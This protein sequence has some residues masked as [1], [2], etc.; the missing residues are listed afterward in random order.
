MVSQCTSVQRKREGET[1]D[2]IWQV[3]WVVVGGL[4]PNKLSTNV[5]QVH[6]CRPD[7][8]ADR[9]RGGLSGRVRCRSE[10]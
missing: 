8:P 7:L 4:S 1:N 9:T 3:L 5:G 6:L 10:A 2:V